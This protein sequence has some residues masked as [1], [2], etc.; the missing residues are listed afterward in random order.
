[1]EQNVEKLSQWLNTHIGHT[2]IIEKK[3]L[4][5]L[6]IVQFSLEAVDYRDAENV[7][8]DYLDSAVILKGHGSTQ[9]KDGD[10][11]PLPQPTY[12]IAVSGLHVDANHEG[13]IQV[14]TERAKYVLSDQE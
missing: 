10:L 2:L 9:N 4:S 8:D 7:I 12:E 1:M 3:E 11:V 13:S 6:D 14:D 5:D